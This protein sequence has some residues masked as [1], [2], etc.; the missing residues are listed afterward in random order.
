MGVANR[1]SFTSMHSVI[2]S[3]NIV[4]PFVKPHLRRIP[5]TEGMAISRL[6]ICRD[7]ARISS[8][9]RLSM[10]GKLCKQEKP[11]FNLLESLDLFIYKDVKVEHPKKSM[12]HAMVV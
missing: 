12:P 1:D 3:S 2:R 6:K 9:F 10:G 5:C 7:A 8:S 4:F 11:E